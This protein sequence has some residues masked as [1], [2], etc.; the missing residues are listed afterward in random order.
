[1][2][3]PCSLSPYLIGNASSRPD[4]R[5]EPY[6]YVLTPISVLNIC[7]HTLVSAE[8]KDDNAA[9]TLAVHLIYGCN[10]SGPTGYSAPLKAM[11]K[12]GPFS[13]SEDS[14]RGDNKDSVSILGGME[15]MKSVP[16]REQC[17]SPSVCLSPK[18]V[19]LENSYGYL[20]AAVGCSSLSL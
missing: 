13:G 5:I 8:K 3:H 19:R 10:T 2:P 1:V 6:S 7:L 12:V 20:G 4:S 11:A 18:H 16:E 9:T 14:F 17:C 15:K